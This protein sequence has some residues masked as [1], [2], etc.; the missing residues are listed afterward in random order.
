[1]DIQRL[2]GT[3]LLDQDDVGSDGKG[4][5]C[6]AGDPGSVRGLGR[7]PGEGNGYSLQY[8]CLESSMDLVEGHWRA[9]VHGI[10]KNWT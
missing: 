7:S 3:H 6:N 4:T 9:T 10:A 5:I 8:S 2:K 1:M